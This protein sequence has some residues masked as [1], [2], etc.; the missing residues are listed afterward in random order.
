MDTSRIPPEFT[1]GAA[2][3]QIKKAVQKLELCRYAIQET[4][5]EIESPDDPEEKADL[6]LAVEDLTAEV[7]ELLGTVKNWTWGQGHEEFDLPE[8]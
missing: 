4:H 8:E 2:K 6:L 7:F 3:T 5:L 1:P